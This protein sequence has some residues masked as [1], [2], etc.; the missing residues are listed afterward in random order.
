MRPYRRRG[1]PLQRWRKIKKNEILS[2]ELF[3]QITA[4]NIELTEYPFWKELAMEAYLIENENVLK[5][6]NDNFSDV[7]ILDAEIALKKGRANGDGRLDLLAQY[8]SEYLA[9]VEIKLHEINDAA[10]TQLEGYLAQRQQITE[11]FPEYWDSEDDIPQ[12]WI[13]VLVGK[14]ISDELRTKLNAGYDFNGIPIAGITLKRYRS[15]NEIFVVS[16]TFF[17][18][19]YTSRDF[20]KFQFNG[21]TYNKGRLVNAVI[22]DYVAKN[23]EL[24]FAELEKRFPKAIQGSYGVFT[25]KEAAELNYQQNGNRK[26]YHINPEDQIQL[27]NAIIATCSQWNTSKIQKF[28]EQAQ[29]LNIKIELD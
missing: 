27:A 7:S 21:K 2:M 15:K 3:R 6:D 16:D 9:I 29:H 20:S 19:K 24:T 26:R 5:L 12:K 1:R 4:N 17:K 23:P 18:A 8:A 13:G 14:D 25:S 10:L 28:I 11:S 22:K